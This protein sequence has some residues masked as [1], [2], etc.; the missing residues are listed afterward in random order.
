[1]ADHRPLLRGELGLFACSAS[2]PIGA[3]LGYPLVVAA[4]IMEIPTY[5]PT[6]RRSMPSEHAGNFGD[7]MALPQVLLNEVSFTLGD[8]LMAHCS[9]LY[10]DRLT[11]LQSLGGSP[12]SFEKLVAITM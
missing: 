6:D 2:P 9:S 12:L 11:D 10:F 5:L 1:M 7:I 8:L 4:V 3:F